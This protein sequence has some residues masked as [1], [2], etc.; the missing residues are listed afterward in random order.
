MKKLLLV[1]VVAAGLAFIGYL[2]FGKLNQNHSEVITI[3]AVL[4]MTGDVASY[5]LGSKE[6]IELAVELANKNSKVAKYKVRYQDSMSSSKGA[7]NAI[8][9]LFLTESPVAIIGDNTSSA[10]GA[11]IPIADKNKTIL[12][13]PSAS[14]SNLSGA[15]QYFFRVFPSD[16]L[17][18]KFVA[19]TISEDY[20]QSNVAVIYVNNDYGNGL[21]DIFIKQ[22][23]SNVV[24]DFGYEPDTKNFRSILAKVK[25]LEPD[26][27][28]MP[29][30]YEDGGILIKQIRESGI[31][32]ALYGATTHVDPKLVEISG[33]NSVGFQYPVSTAFDV[34]SS[35]KY[36]RDFVKAFKEKYNKE[37]GLLAALGFDCAQLIIS[38]VE[39]NG[40]SSESIRSYLLSS[41]DIAGATGVMNFDE[42]GDVTKSIVMRKISK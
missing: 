2:L 24:G 28:Y 23:K 16:V 6:G 9:S 38:G 18:G 36:T 21:R 40:I 20:P 4:P 27:I 26:V 37:P 34:D 3:G 39:Q 14:A 15:S 42:K 41:S 30:Y 13:S 19:Q 8:E 31:Y 1:V 7:V 12:I 35:D 11:I 25:A 33:I 22:S 5:G 29:S 10:T 32:A 17:E